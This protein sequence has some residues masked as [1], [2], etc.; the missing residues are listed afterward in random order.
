VDVIAV[1]GPWTGAEERYE[2]DA[3]RYVD[4]DLF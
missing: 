2:A 4:L 1:I 3:V